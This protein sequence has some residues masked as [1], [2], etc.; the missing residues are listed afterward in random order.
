MEYWVIDVTW[1]IWGFKMGKGRT[2]WYI[3]AK[4]DVSSM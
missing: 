1:G 4:V 3:A 2:R